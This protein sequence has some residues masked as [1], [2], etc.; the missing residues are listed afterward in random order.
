MIVKRAVMN[1]DIPAAIPASMVSDSEGLC[2]ISAKIVSPE[3]TDLYN[4]LV[5]VV[6]TVNRTGIAT[7]KP[8]DHLPSLVTGIIFNVASCVYDAMEWF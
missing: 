3:G 6:P 7:I 1:A 2:P 4:V 8:T 5:K